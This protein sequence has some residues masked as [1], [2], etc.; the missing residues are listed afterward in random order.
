LEDGDPYYRSLCREY[1]FLRKKYRLKPIEG[2]LFKKMR[3]RPVNFPH[4]RIAQAAALWINRDVLFSEILEVEAIHA[5]RSLL[6][7][8]P[9]EYWNTHYHFGR[10]SFSR[11]KTIGKKSADTLLINTVVPLLFAYGKQKERPDYCDRALKF[12][13]ELPPERNHLVT[14]FEKA[15]ISVG[16]AGDTQ[17]LIQLRRAYCDCKKCLYCRIGFRMIDN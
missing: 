6:E 5:V 11:K 16:N 14:F 10:A 13:E 2:F 3:T 1:E 12:L 15:G 9:S 4:V 8:S 7:A 17:A